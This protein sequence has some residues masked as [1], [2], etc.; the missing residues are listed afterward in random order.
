MTSSVSITVTK[1]RR[2]SMGKYLVVRCQRPT[3]WAWDGNVPSCRIGWMLRQPL[4][5][6]PVV[7]GAPVHLPEQKCTTDSMGRELA[8]CRERGVLPAVWLGR[9][10]GAS[11]R[12]RGRKQKRVSDPD[13]CLGRMDPSCCS[14]SFP[15][16]TCCVTN[17]GRSVRWCHGITEAIVS[18][19]SSHSSKFN[20]TGEILCWLRLVFWEL[21][22]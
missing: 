3:F 2:F 14:R 8:L 12:Q 22:L 16:P 9:D 4:L 19:L 17:M 20:L 6:D 13:K 18:L 5:C 1:C 10:C 11:R 7:P 21:I 15:A